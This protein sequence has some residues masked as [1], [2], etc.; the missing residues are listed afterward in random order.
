M[1]NFYGSMGLSELDS[2]GTKQKIQRM[3]KSSLEE[4]HL[5]ITTVLPLEVMDIV[6]TLV[7][8][9]FLEDDVD[10]PNMTIT[11]KVIGTPYKG[12]LNSYVDDVDEFVEKV[13]EYNQRAMDIV[14]DAVGQ[15]H[16]FLDYKGPEE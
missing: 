2:H 14:E 10:G 12:Y 3:L 1:L 8:E 7:V 15:F 5:K 9:A 11:W 6:P 16:F 13:K 4:V